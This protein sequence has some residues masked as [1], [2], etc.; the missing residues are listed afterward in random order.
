MEESWRLHEVYYI[1][2]VNMESVWLKGSL[3]R[4]GLFGS[5]SE[6]R[7]DARLYE[8]H[9]PGKSLFEIINNKE[10]VSTWTMNSADEK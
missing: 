7:Q 10:G 4:K 8:F 9:F 3:S 5:R 6:E 1:G 2:L